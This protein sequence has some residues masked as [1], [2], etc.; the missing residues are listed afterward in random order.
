MPPD[1][2]R[3]LEPGAWLSW[4]IAI[5]SLGLTAGCADSPRSREEIAGVYK[6]VQPAGEGLERIFTLELRGDSSCSLS[7]EY[8]K[9]GKATERG[10]WTNQ[11]SKVVVHL[12]PR[13]TNHPPQVVEFKWR[14][15]TLT[16]TKW[17]EALYGQEGLGTFIREQPGQT[18]APPR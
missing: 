11:S 17:D 14:G 10:I 7:R 9:K 2:P 15:R 6:H 16:S 4:S 5:I 12:M 18:N 8:V 13:K 1:S 3:G